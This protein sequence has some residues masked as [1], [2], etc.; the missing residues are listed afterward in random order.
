MGIR[1]RTSRFAHVLERT[2]LAMAGASCGLFVAAHLARTA[3]ET[4]AS[5]SAI[6]AMT[7]YGAIGFYLGIDIPPHAALAGRNDPAEMLSAIGTFSATVA[8]FISVYII[9]VDSDLYYAWS[10]AIWVW[11][12]L[13]VSLQI[14]AGTIARI[15][16]L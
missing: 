8:A 12:L 6:V 14:V 2:G 1:S 13:G 16:A 7:V 3:I 11:W 10:I 5:L 4:F 9:A 15:R